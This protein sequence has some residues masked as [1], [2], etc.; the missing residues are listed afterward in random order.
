MLS[1]GYILFIQ[2][3]VDAFIAIVHA[4][5]IFAAGFQDCVTN[6][7]SHLPISSYFSRVIVFPMFVCENN[8]KSGFSTRCRP[9]AKLTFCKGTEYLKKPERNFL[10][11]TVLYFSFPLSINFVR[12]KMNERARP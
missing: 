7:S 11:I 10:R 6:H 4:N 3:L 2:S 9:M 5:V 8:N 1:L 12:Q